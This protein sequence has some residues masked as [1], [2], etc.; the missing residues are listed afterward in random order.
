MKMCRNDYERLIEQ[1]PVIPT[2]I[3]NY[4]KIKYRNISYLILPDACDKLA[5]TTVFKKNDSKSIDNELDSLIESRKFINRQSDVIVNIKPVDEE[6]VKP[7]NLPTDNI[8]DH[9][10]NL[11]INRSAK[12]LKN[13]SNIIKSNTLNISKIIQ[14]DD[15][16]L[17]KTIVKIPE[18]IDKNKSVKDLISKFNKES[19]FPQ[20]I[21]GINNTPSNNT[22]SNNTPSNNTPSNNTSSNTTPKTTPKTIPNITRSMYTPILTSKYKPYLSSINEISLENSNIY[23]EQTEQ[24]EQTEQINNLNEI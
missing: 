1:S 2:E 16:S 4:F 5:H 22:P 7:L 8:I 19:P 12:Q 20:T 17:E 23:S 21:Y 6:F 24:T 10:N 9:T 3:I 11:S 15:N 13:K 18:I 14:K